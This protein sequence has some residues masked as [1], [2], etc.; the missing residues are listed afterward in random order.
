MARR[1]TL[2]WRAIAAYSMALVGLA[3]ASTRRPAGLLLGG[4]LLAASALASMASLGLPEAIQS[5]S[6]AVPG[7]VKSNLTVHLTLAHAW[8]AIAGASLVAWG[9]GVGPSLW[10]MDTAVHAITLGFMFNV[11]FGVDAVLLYGHAGIPLDKV[12][13]PSSIPGLL[14]NS[15]L[16]LR[17]VYGFT[18]LAPSLAALSGPLAGLGIVFFYGRNIAKLRNLL[19]MPP[20][21]R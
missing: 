9:L 16:V 3:S 6:R 7:Y 5:S 12:P 20:A 10:A 8:L 2:A 13:R 17:A 21:T 1:R 4:I 18:G 15:A 14:L 11:I 19:M